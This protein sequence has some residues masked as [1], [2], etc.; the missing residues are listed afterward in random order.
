M[1]FL[2]RRKNRPISRRNKPEYLLFKKTG[3]VMSEKNFIP[4][5][6]PGF[7]KGPG[8]QFVPNLFDNFFDDFVGGRF[9]FACFKCLFEQRRAVL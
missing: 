1:E 2:K 9:L 3:K 4:V 6:T 8:L 7:I 5:K